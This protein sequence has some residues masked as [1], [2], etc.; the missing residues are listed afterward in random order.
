VLRL[1]AFARELARRDP[2]VDL[3]RAGAARDRNVE[4]LLRK[5]F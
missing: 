1:A 2:Q 3:G 4:L 5:P